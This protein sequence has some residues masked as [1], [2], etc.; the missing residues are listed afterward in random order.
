MNITSTMQRRIQVGILGY[1][2]LMLSPELSNSGLSLHLA[3]I[4]GC[5]AFLVMALH[6]V[7]PGSARQSHEPK[8]QRE[9]EFRKLRLSTPLLQG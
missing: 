3:A 6:A 2:L 5:V 4:A 1:G 8:L 9:F 7:V